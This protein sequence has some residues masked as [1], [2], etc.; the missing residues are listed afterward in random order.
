MEEEC[1]ARQSDVVPVELE[2][3]VAAQEVVPPGMHWEDHTPSQRFRKWFLGRMRLPSAHS[4]VV[5]DRIMDGRD[6]WT[7]LLGPRR[8]FYDVYRWRYESVVMGD[9]LPSGDA[10]IV[11]RP[12][13]IWALE[14]TFPRSVYPMDP[15]Q[16]RIVRP[17]IGLHR[18]TLELR[19]QEPLREL[20]RE[21]V[22]H[23]PRQTPWVFLR[24]T[25]IDVAP[26]VLSRITWRAP[27]FRIIL[28][29]WGNPTLHPGVLARLIDAAEPFFPDALLPPE[30]A[31]GGRHGD[32]AGDPD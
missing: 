28:D 25:D 3:L 30:H 18:K 17:I 1:S 13:K 23:H 19:I 31:L 29:H 2:A 24:V 10:L 12:G 8:L 21:A 9:V 15:G 32:A 27:R 5:T 11:C 14:W 16:D 26:E 7:V 4:V 22:K 20:W 6:R